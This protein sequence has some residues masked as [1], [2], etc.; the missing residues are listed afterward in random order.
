MAKVCCRGQTVTPR[1]RHSSL[2]R[3][4]PQTCSKGQAGG[5][6]ASLLWA[7]GLM[8]AAC[9]GTCRARSRL[10]SLVA[11]CP[12][13]QDCF[14]DSRALLVSCMFS[15]LQGQAGSQALFSR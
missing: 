3:W 15:S 12:E 14:V 1:A 7:A 5:V 11:T 6:S 8:K 10:Q 2:V 4:M 9:S 13:V